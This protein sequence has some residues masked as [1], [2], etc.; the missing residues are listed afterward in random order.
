MAK[1]PATRAYARNTRE[2]AILVQ[3]GMTPG[4]I[5]LEG[6]HGE[7][8]GRIRMRAGELLA[9]VGG[10][11]PLGGNRR[12]IVAAVTGLHAMGAAVLDIAS[13]Q[14]SDRDGVVMLD[15]A[16]RAIRGESVMPPGKAQDMAHRSARARTAGRMPK[17][18]ALAIW[19]DARLTIGQAIE[20]MPGWSARTAYNLLGPRGL[21]TGRIGR[22]K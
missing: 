14:R 13:G 17:R 5:Y 6:R 20:R 8:L 22:T 1:A 7:T 15:A 11:R 4:A 12:D 19:R 10:L 16:L 18:E 3:S 2:E 9:T 21:P